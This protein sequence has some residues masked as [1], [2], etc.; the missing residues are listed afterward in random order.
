MIDNPNAQF[1]NNLAGDV[2]GGLSAAIITTP[3]AIGYGIMAFAP[4]GPEF[5]QQAVMAG[6]FSAFFGGSPI[7]ITGPKAPLTLIYGTLVSSVVAIQAISMERIER[8]EFNKS[9]DHQIYE[10]PC[11]GN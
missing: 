2:L 4:L 6:L 7:Q 1:K 9:V 10:K 8:A 3:M 5:I 11:L